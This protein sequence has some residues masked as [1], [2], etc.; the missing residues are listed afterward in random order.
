MIPGSTSVCVWAADLLMM[1]LLVRSGWCKTWPRAH[2]NDKGVAC[3]SPTV[4]VVFWLAFSPPGFY[5]CMIYMRMMVSAAHCV[6][7]PIYWSLLFDWAS[8]YPDFLKG[9]VIC[10]V[11]TESKTERKITCKIDVNDIRHAAGLLILNKD[12][13]KGLV[14]QG[15]AELCVK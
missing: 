11:T 7:I 1:W 3:E 5:T 14:K 8:V 12:L 2:A 10:S 6:V 4:C 15:K 9:T 13:F